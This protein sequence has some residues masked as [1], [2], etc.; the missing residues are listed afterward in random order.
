M[1]ILIRD[2]KELGISEQKIARSIN[3]HL[4]NDCVE[5]QYLYHHQRYNTS[6]LN[7]MKRALSELDSAECY[8]TGEERFNKTRQ[9]PGESALNFMDRVEFECKEIFGANNG[10]NN[11]KIK[12]HFIENFT[13]NGI[14]LD[15][16]KYN[17][18]NAY[19]DLHELALAAEG[20]LNQKPSEPTKDENK[21][22]RSS[23]HKQKVTAEE[24]IK[25]TS[26]EGFIVCFKCSETL[27]LSIQ[28]RNPRFCSICNS[29]I[30]H[31]TKQHYK[32]KFKD[33]SPSPAPFLDKTT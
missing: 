31:T 3:C 9:L 18:L 29:S 19:Y 28:C 24:V 26:K 1:L 20:I 4:L 33:T 22:R 25:G 21:D 30:N 5:S 15:L 6:S 8:L 32:C 17:W 7:D 11:R 16:Q 12:K 2:A 23:S 14:G 27:H 13:L 10:A